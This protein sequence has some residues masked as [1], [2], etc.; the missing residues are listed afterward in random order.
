LMI[1][2]VF[3]FGNKEELFINVRNLDFQLHVGIIFVFAYDLN[4]LT[5]CVN[6]DFLVRIK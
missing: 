5:S 4:R 1:R 6:V 2:Y 3:Q